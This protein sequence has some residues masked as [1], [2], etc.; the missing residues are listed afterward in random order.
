MI[1]IATTTVSVWRLPADNALDGFDPQPTRVQVASGL[2]ATIG[3]PS[4]RASIATGDKVVVGFSLSTDPF[5]FANDDQL[6]DES[7][8]ETYLLLWARRITALGLDHCMGAVRI[9]QGAA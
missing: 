4:G 6:V 3:A 5:D 8:G 1:P 9:V 2:R 7:T